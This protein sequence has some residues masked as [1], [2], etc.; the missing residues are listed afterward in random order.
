MGFKLPTVSKFLFCLE[1]ET[2]GIVLGC[3]SA[4]VSILMIFLLA[5][6]LTATIFTLN[7]LELKDEGLQA[8]IIGKIRFSSSTTNYDDP[9]ASSRHRRVYTLHR[10][11][12]HPSKR[13]N[14]AGCG[15][16]KGET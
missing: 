15:N 14:F 16:E 12:P 6:Q 11:L 3:L 4:V 10:L 8:F 2:G 13:C 7:S 1:L 9:I 5:L